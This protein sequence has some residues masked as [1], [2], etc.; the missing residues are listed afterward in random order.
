MAE[1]L[2][3]EQIAR[4]IAA[5]AIARKAIA[6]VVIDV[7]GNCDYADFLVVCSGRSDRQVDGIA[8]GIDADCADLGI[9][10]IGNEGLADGQWVLMDFADVVVHVFNGSKRNEYDIEGLWKDAPR[11]DIEV[12][13]E[14][15]MTDEIYDDLED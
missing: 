12:P 4:K 13:P 10:S 3:S 6:P 9:E 14:L 8:N 2:T 1:E 11:L 7:R 5:A 15:R